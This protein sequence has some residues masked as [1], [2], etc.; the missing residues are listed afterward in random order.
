MERLLTETDS[1][2]MGPEKGVRNDPRSVIR[3][4][5]IIAS[6][7]EMEIVELKLRIRDNFKDLF[8]VWII[9]FDLI[10]LLESKSIGFR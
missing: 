7:K 3:G 2:Y 1:P 5:G 8:G 10:I 6:I 9:L 4:V